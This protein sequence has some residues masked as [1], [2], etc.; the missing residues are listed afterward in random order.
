MRTLTRRWREIPAVDVLTDRETTRFL[1]VSAIV[2]VGV[3][4]GAAALV[5]VID[6][7]AGGFETLEEL[8]GGRRWWV[9]IAVPLGFLGAW[10]LARHLAPEVEGDGVPDVIA[11]LALR[12]GRIPGRVIPAKIV[13]TAFTLGGGGSGGREGPIVQIGGAVGSVISRF[14]HLG[15]DQIRSLV[16]AG[17]GAGIGASFNAPITGMLFAMEVILGS[18]AVRHLSAIV[19]ASVVA[20]I[21]SRSIVGEELSLRAASYTLEDPRQLVVFLLLSAVAAFAGLALLRGVDM[22]DRWGRARPHW[23]GWRP[24]AFGLV[25]GAIGLLEP[26][27]LGTGQA[28]LGQVLAESELVERVGIGGAAWWALILLAFVKLVATAFT[29]TSGGAG[30]AFFPSLFI[31]ASLGAGLGRLIEPFWGF[32]ILKPGSLAVVGMATVIAAVARAPLTAM[33]IAFEITGAR[34]YGLVLPLMLGTVMATFIADRFHTDSLYSAT[35]RRRGINV[36]PHGEMDLLDTVSVGEVMHHPHATAD[37]DQSL[38][39]AQQA[40]SRYRYNGLV[41]LKDGNVAGVVTVADV[42]RAGGPSDSVLVSQ[43]MTARPVTVTASTPVSRALER[44]ASLGIGRLP[45]VA[46]D[47]SGRFVGLFRREEAVRAY[48]R[49][50]GNRTDRELGRRRL[51]QRTDPGVGYYDFRVPAGSIAED[52]TVRE[53]AWPQGSTLVSVRRDREVIIPSGATTLLAGDVITAFGTPS[54]RN[55]MIERLNAGADEPTAELSLEEIEQA[56]G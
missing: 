19:I 45:V 27:V 53:V 51:D 29:T 2:G 28:F 52:K 3:G 22:L 33:M 34:D 18:F 5:L 9:L 16:A 42:I 24:V 21:T 17:A 4:A 20:A 35:L 44:L 15:P 48:H 49:A 10:W 36:A 12:D 50:L 6:A 40:M 43:A 23:R 41:V 7:I 56:E 32:G 38:A 46:E 1:A 55:E 26:D 37:P 30:G 39:E 54:S 31:G 25:V 14:F 13:A 47:G 8:A 11:A